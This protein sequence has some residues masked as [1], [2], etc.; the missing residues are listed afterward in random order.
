MLSASGRLVI[1]FNGEIYNFA[2]LRTELA[3]LGHGFR[4]HSDTEVALAAVEQWGITGAL[5]RF[6]GM[7]AFVIWDKTER[8]LHLARDRIGEKP[9]YYG[10]IGGVFVFAS[11]LKA[12]RAVP[13]WWGDINREA[14][15]LFLRHNYIPAPHSIYRD[16]HKLPPAMLLTVPA[17]ARPARISRQVYWS[18]GAIVEAGCS[19]PVTQDAV[20]AADRL[21]A[22]LHDA[23][24]QKMVADVPLG[25]FLSGGIDSSTVVAIMQAR[26]TMPVRT[27][28]IGFHEADYNEAAAAKLVAT[29]LGT[30]HTELYVTHGDALA[31]IPRLPS[32]YDE[33]FADSS[34]IPTFLVAQLASRHVKVALSGD[35]G[36]E[37]FGG[38][39]RYFWGRELWRVLRLLPAGL[40]NSMGHALWHLAH[41]GRK[42]ATGAMAG[43]LP[44]R[45]RVSNPTEK[46]AKLAEIVGIRNADDMYYRLISHWKD[47]AAVV[48]GGREPSTV[49][50]D[51]RAWPRLNDFPARMM[52]LDLVSYLPDDILVKVDR[53]SMGVSLE[54]RVPL[55]DH[56]IVEFAWRVPLR[57]RMRHNQGKWLLRQVLRRYVP[58]KLTQ[59]PKS[60]FAIPLGEWLRGALRDW[61]EALIAEDR[62]KREGF[63]NPGPI[64][65]KWHEHLSGRG[66]WQY[67]LWSVLMFQAWLDTEPVL[68]A[69]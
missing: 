24:A 13:G 9:L 61:C 32:L 48:I 33:P 63:F 51:R 29:H 3:G 19:N 15:T 50:T 26:S 47:P 58:E 28:T 69:K 34:Q 20:E 55:L 54:A 65:Q 16:I 37:L 5:Q 68:Q 11:E 40:R 30:A 23:I 66:N 53:A 31:V 35:G 21:E 14:L 1:T 39:N 41:S 38:Y 8:V 45:L 56:R 27:F 17:D 7:F 42:D 62:L 60:G 6:V 12:L 59:R 22:L 46:L 36:D 18:A 2:E 4:G 10:W 57:I 64:V 52:Y 44:E 49:V 25:A 43:L 67:Y